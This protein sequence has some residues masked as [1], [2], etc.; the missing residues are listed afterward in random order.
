MIIIKTKDDVPATIIVEELEGAYIARVVVS[1]ADIDALETVKLLL[2]DKI[3][4]QLA[5]AMEAKQGG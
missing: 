4:Q 3:I 1:G 2:A 5:R